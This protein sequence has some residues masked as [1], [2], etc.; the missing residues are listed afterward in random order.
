MVAPGKLLR[1]A[2]PG[3][4]A[5]FARICNHGLGVVIKR[6][7]SSLARA[8][9]AHVVFRQSALSFDELVVDEGTV[10]LR[11]CC[12]LSACMDATCSTELGARDEE[13]SPGYAVRATSRIHGREFRPSEPTT[14]VLSYHAD[15]TRSGNFVIPVLTWDRARALRPD[16]GFMRRSRDM[17]MRS[18][19]SGIRAAP[20]RAR[21]WS[22]RKM[23]PSTLS[24]PRPVRRY[25]GN[26]SARRCRARRC[27]AATSAR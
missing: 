7:S 14:E 24:M 1:P 27:L 17:S 15:L 21:C 9:R 19:S 12:N 11:F 13:I 3:A 25:G 5:C 22:R 10:A 2:Q 20:G 18:R 8:E 4:A 16:G 6:H 26:R 23:I